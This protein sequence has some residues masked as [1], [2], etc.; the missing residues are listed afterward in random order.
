MRRLPRARWVGLVFAAAVVMGLPTLRGG[1]VGSDDHRLVINHVYVNRP[2]LDHAVELFSIVHR[3]LYQPLPLLSFQAEF[4]VAGLLGQLEQGAKSA[5][6]LFHLDNCLLHGLNSVLLGILLFLLV[7][8]PPGAD[9]VTARSCALSAGQAEAVAVLGGLL[10]AV[11]PVQTEVVAWVNGRMILMSTCFGLLSLLSFRRLCE[12]RGGEEEDS[13]APTAGWLVL[14]LVLVV[15]CAISKIRI[16]L[17]VLFFV[18]FLAGRYRFTRRA[19]AGWIGCVLL[20]LLFTYVNIRSTEGVDLFAQAAEQLRGPRFARVALALDNYFAHLVWPVG[21][22]SYYPT[23]PVVAWSDPGVI[24][25]TLV[26]VVV[27]AIWT[28]AAIRWRPALWG[29]LWFFSTLFATLPFFPARNVMAADRYLYLPLLGLLWPVSLAVVRALSVRPRLRL[30]GASVGAAVGVVLIGVC[31]HVGRAYGDPL[32][33]TRRI[34]MLFSDAPRVWERYGWVLID[35][36]RF[37]EAIDAA[38]RELRWEN[39]SV[40]CGAL[41]LKAMAL[42]ELGRVDEAVPLLREAMALLPDNQRPR[43]RLGK[44]FEEQGDLAR[45]AEMYEAALAVSPKHYPSLI[46]LAAI[47]RDG[48]RLAEARALYERVLEEN[49]FDPAAT[50]GVA[51]VALASGDPR[52]I[53]EAKASLERLLI[54]VPDVA[55]IWTVLGEVRFSL[56]DSSGAVSAYRRAIEL[57]DRNAAALLNLAE[58]FRAGGDEEGALSLY[59]RA[60]DVGPQSRAQAVAI[61]DFFLARKDLSRACVAVL[62]RGGSQDPMVAWCRALGG[63]FEAPVS[64]GDVTD[65]MLL[66]A[67]AMQALHEGQVGRATEAVESLSSIGDAAADAQG[68]LLLGLEFFDTTSPQNPWTFCLTARLL[69]SQGRI[70]PARAFLNLCEQFD[71][72]GDAREYRERLKALI[73]A[74]PRP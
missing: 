53:E 43:F 64:S 61:H 49:E 47:R 19:W 6:W 57:D 12:E 14:T 74:A 23:P 18:V 7:R 16:G 22:A 56:G 9:S 73:E 48:G 65:P 27:L 30:A 21:L 15:L 20:S 72:V 44:I 45:A 68:R 40:R 26:S 46:R 28:V 2:S 31:W 32:S 34:A 67:G 62:P 17:P 24:R 69:M 50:A 13:L 35:E 29:A 8:P 4:A 3:D 41:Q 51:R 58:I 55:E 25:A 60:A 70:E 52:A 42:Y 66:A 54:T 37:E 10:F 39:E 71:S 1:F 59:T 63:G 36:G 33:K 11:H 5:A 38:E